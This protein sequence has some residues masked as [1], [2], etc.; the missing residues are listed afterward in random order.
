MTSP[1]P[2][3]GWPSTSLSSQA[4]RSSIDTPREALRVRIEQAFIDACLLD[5]T[6]LKPGNV[7]VHGAGH[8]MQAIDFVRSARAAAPAITGAAAGVGERIARALAAT[9]AVCGM[10][11]NLGIVLLAAP[12][13]EA[14]QRVRG[15]LSHDSLAVELGHV[16]AAL[17]V[18]DA[19]YAFEAIRL[20][21]PGG[22]GDAVRHDVREPARV[23]LLEAMREAAERDSIARQYATA[24]ADVKRIGLA[25]LASCRGGSRRWAATEVFLGFLSNLPDSHVARKFGAAQAEALRDEARMR[26]QAWHACQASRARLA[27]LREWDADLKV[28]ALNPGT[29]ADLTVATLFWSFLLESD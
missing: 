27:A 29:S 21:R 5:I 2:A 20:A 28:R 25:R 4:A 15:P 14:V 1:Q 8:R 12:I 17:T 18:D 22:L 3:G 7:G 23:S 11:T 13:C 19:A 6:A 9:Q 10:N 26:M 16:L 24:Y